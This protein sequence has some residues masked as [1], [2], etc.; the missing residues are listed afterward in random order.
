MMAIKI[1][2]Y[3]TTK[4]KNIKVHKK[5]NSTFAPKPKQQL[6]VIPK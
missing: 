3:K 4:E 6:S 1:S 2:D 5:D